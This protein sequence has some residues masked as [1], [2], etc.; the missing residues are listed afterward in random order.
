MNNARLV[1]Q[2]DPAAVRQGEAA[3][4]Q[5]WVA[6][7]PI[8]VGGVDVAGTKT[9][10]APVEKHLRTQRKPSATA[11]PERDTHIDTVRTLQFNSHKFL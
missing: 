2:V 8:A 9:S 7:L 3:E 11:P 6:T 4:K 10:Q 5:G 1:P